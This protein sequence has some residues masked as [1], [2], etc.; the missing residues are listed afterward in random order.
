MARLKFNT[1][2]ANGIGSNLSRSALWTVLQ[3]PSESIDGLSAPMVL[4]IHSK[5]RRFEQSK[6]VAGTQVVHP[7][8]SAPV[9]LIEIRDRVRRNND[10]DGIRQM[11]YQPRNVMHIFEYAS[12]HGHVMQGNRWQ[13][14]AIQIANESSS[15]SVDEV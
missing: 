11:R 13:H 12:E 14:F 9:L 4:A 5:S 8:I 15:A 10:F 6:D 7:S 2:A 3:L 1:K